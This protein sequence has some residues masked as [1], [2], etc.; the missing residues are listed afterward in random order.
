[1]G[2]GLQQGRCGM[3]CVMLRADANSTRAAT[4]SRRTEA[5]KCMQK[6]RLDVDGMWRPRVEHAG[7][8]VEREVAGVRH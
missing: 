6:G 8:R 3:A 2:V 4:Q 7:N 5:K 1:M